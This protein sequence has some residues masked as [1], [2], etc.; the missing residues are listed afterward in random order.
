VAAAPH[1]EE[2]QEAAADDPVDR[3]DDQLG[4]DQAAHI[5]EGCARGKLAEPAEVLTDD[6]MPITAAPKEA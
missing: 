6:H 3:A 5:A 2:A 1:L 4:A